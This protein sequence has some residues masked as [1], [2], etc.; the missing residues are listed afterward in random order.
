MIACVILALLLTPFTY[1]FF[2][3]FFAYLV[4]YI[5]RFKKRPWRGC[6]VPYLGRSRRLIWWHFKRSYADLT[7]S[8]FKCVRNF[9]QNRNHNP[10]DSLG[11]WQENTNDLKEFKNKIIQEIIKSLYDKFFFFFTY[12]PQISNEYSKRWIQSYT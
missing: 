10:L 12:I 11:N 3:F 9:L 6:N 2:F 1:Y 5:I 8:L 4:L 7:G